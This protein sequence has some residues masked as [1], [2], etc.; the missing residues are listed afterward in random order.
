M[1]LH[2]H[3]NVTTSTT[4]TTRVIASCTYYVNIFTLL[5]GLCFSKITQKLVIFLEAEGSGLGQDTFHEMLVSN[6][7]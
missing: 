7:F 4:H 2:H 5:V 1:L 3:I 6:A